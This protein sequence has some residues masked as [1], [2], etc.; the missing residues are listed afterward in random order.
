MVYSAIIVTLNRLELLKKCIEHLDEQTHPLDYLVIVDNASTDGTVE[1]LKSVE[2]DRIRVIY[3]QENKGGAYGFYV[4]IKYAYDIGTDY[5][6]L[7][8]DDTIATST[9]L[10]ELINGF[11]VTR[12]EPV[13]FITSNVLFKDGSPCLMNISNCEFVWNKHISDSLVRV[14]HSSF[15]SMMVPRNVIKTVGLPFK[16]FFIWGDD[17]EYSTRIASS[18][19]GYVSGKSVVYHYMNEN[20]GVDIFNTPGDRIGRFYYFYRNW[21][22]TNKFRGEAEARA[23]KADTKRL[24]KTIKKSKISFKSAKI[25]VI[26]KGLRDGKKM[27]ALIDFPDGREPQ[28]GVKKESFIQKFKRL[29][30]NY[31]Y[32]LLKELDKKTSNKFSHTEVLYKLDNRINNS[33]FHKFAFLFKGLI[34]CKLFDAKTKGEAFYNLMGSVHIDKHNNSRFFSS[35]DIYKCWWLRNRQMDNCPPDYELFVNNSLNDLLFSGDNLG[36]FEKNSNL[37]IKGIILFVKRSIKAISRSN[38][39]NKKNIV[40]W[41]TDFI[42]K[43]ASHLEEAL[44]RIIIVNQLFWQTG[45]K[46]VGYGRLDLICDNVLKNDDDLSDDQIRDILCDFLDAQHKYYVFKSSAL[47]GDTGQIVILGGNISEKKYFSN[48]LTLQ[49]IRAIE[50]MQ[51]PDPKVLL[52][53]SNLTPSYLW[54]AALKCASTGVGCPLFSNDERVIPSLI[55]FGYERED[56]Y[57][58]STSACWEPIPGNCY[59][60]NNIGFINFAEPF[61]LISKKDDLDRIKSFDEYLWF[62]CTHMKGHSMFMV[63]LLD[64]IIW[65]SDPLLSTC[66]K[67]CRQNKIDVSVGGAKYNNY[68]VLSIAM[69]N[70][71]NSLLNVKKYVFEDHLFTLKQLNE[72]R[73]DDFRGHDDVLKL[74]KNS[75]NEFGKDKQYVRDLTNYILSQVDTHLSSYRNRFGGRVK[76][77]LSSPSYLEIGKISKATFDGRKSGEPYGTHISADFGVAYT[78]LMNFSSKLNY[79]GSKFNGNVVDIMLSPDFINNNRE[80]FTY[81]MEKIIKEG[82][83]QLQLNVVSSDLLIKAKANPSLMPNLIVR[84]WGF[85]AYFNELPEEYQNMLI[86]RARRNE[87]V[88]N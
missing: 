83:F 57:N 16:E 63:K 79:D 45:H 86:E 43:P 9:A 23:F 30:H 81:F 11:A 78:E 46:L 56:A 59:E 87:L 76:F 74:L 15:V 34:R 13:G 50:K 5:F 85:S 82:V 31:F 69:S 75:A 84:V 6:W 67:I 37:V 71:V 80:K 42:D 20:K 41:L 4:G 51:L 32:D 2:N 72:M 25:K 10:Q 14:R 53:V 22:F 66:S 48:R 49:F 68:G 60:Q 36:E 64:N 61:D 8:D 18:F 19:I 21:M 33:L 24:I 73:L 38:H 58:Y 54:D 35:I 88:Y 3:N 47:V 7:M 1:Y 77:G 52:R 40:K 70:A 27:K 17:G 55:G 39:H 65:E 62:Y 44:Q 12:D 29:L 26:K 28:G